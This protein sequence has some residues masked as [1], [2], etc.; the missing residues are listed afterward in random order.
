MLAQ[1]REA[2]CHLGPSPEELPRSEADLRIFAH[3]L[4]HWSH[5]KDYRTLDAFPPQALEKYTLHIVR[6]SASGELTQEVLHGLHSTGH[7]PFCV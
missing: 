6:M 4:L 5:D 2:C 1:A 7:K 3:D